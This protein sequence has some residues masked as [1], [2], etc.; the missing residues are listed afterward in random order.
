M[1]EPPV[2]L[3]VGGQSYRVHSDANP[4]ELQRLA[5]LLDDRIR[6]CNA[7]GRLSPTQALLF[8]AL[9][10]TDELQKERERR[11]LLE[12]KARTA[13][14]DVLHRIDAA[15]DASDLLLTDAVERPPT[16]PRA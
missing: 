12:A 1:P 7:T 3:T 5:R 6:A 16:A 13:L 11:Q 2:A 15:L 4:A 10:L 9:T 8:A 14:Q